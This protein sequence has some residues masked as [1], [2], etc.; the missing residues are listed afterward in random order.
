MKG[1]GVARE[2]NVSS[3]AEVSARTTLSGPTRTLSLTLTGGGTVRTVPAGLDCTSSCDAEL[4]LGVNVALHADPQSGWTFN[5]W[6]G[7]CTGATCSVAMSEDR[8][9]TAT[10]NATPGT[11]LYLVT[12]CRVLDTRDSA[13][14]AADTTRTLGFSGV[15]GIPST[16]NAIALNVTVV[17]PAAA[18][19]LT[20]HPADVARPLASTI[21]FRPARTR[22]NNAIA[23]VSTATQIAI[24]NGGTSPVHV[25]VDVTGWFE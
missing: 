16:A 24:Y 22:A 3:N 1:D 9:V 20:L 8:A 25:L 17:A 18:G 12:P 23:A 14:V 6:G 2:E 19:W 11:K 15:C 10:F 7:A 21:S 5:A 13:A 4:R